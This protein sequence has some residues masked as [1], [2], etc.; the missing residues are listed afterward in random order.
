MEAGDIFQL[1]YFV[2]IVF[3]FFGSLIRNIMK[4]FTETS[5]PRSEA[6]EALETELSLEELLGQ[7]RQSELLTEKEDENLL[8][9]AKEEIFGD[10]NVQKKRERKRKERRRML[11][12][13]KERHQQKAKALQQDLETSPATTSTSYA[14]LLS[15][16]ENLRQ[17]FIMSEIFKRKY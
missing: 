10:K 17:A 14:K 6:D 9:K 2:V 1:I 11:S 4:K 8:E 12:K 13:I 15:D 5:I 7:Q 16:S 3:V